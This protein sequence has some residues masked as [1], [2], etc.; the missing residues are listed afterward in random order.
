MLY[1]WA[2]IEITPGLRIDERELDFN[3]IRAA[4]PGGQN[5]NKVATAVQLRFNPKGS[6][7]L[8]EDVHARDGA[9]NLEDRH[10]AALLDA[11]AGDDSRRRAQVPLL[12]G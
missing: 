7:S 1:T 12:C 9:E 4:G 11:F 8:P 6:A 3:F 10:R 5:V 2:M